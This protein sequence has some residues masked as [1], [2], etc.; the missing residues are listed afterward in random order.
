M[1]PV[2]GE[3]LERRV[4]VRFDLTD[5]VHVVL[6][7]GTRRIP[8]R[9]ID[10]ALAGCAV[11]CDVDTLVEGTKV[12]VILRGASEADIARRDAL[13]VSCF[14]L[15]DEEESERC[16]L[17]FDR[18]ISLESHAW[19]S[20]AVGSPLRDFRSQH[21]LFE[22]QREI[23]LRDLDA[24]EARA[25]D[26]G[27]CQFQ[28]FLTGIPV[29]LGLLGTAFAFILRTPLTG[30]PAIH[31]WVIVLPAASAMTAISML[32]VLLRKSASIAR[33]R[34][35]SLLLQRYLAAGRLPGRY[36]GREDA[37]ANLEHITRFG[38]LE[39]SLLTVEPMGK[40][41][42]VLRSIFSANSFAGLSILILLLVQALSLVGV[43]IL[44][45]LGGSDT[46]VHLVIAAVATSLVAAAGVNSYGLIRRV[47]HGDL[48][49]EYMVIQLSRI[50]EH[51]A[52]FDPW[53]S[54]GY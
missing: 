17:Y 6:L 23:A 5:A 29:F 19:L 22:A 37:L 15:A 35:L 26:S 21:S 52:M 54:K 36:R 16:G 4:G 27:S 8:V 20:M 47:Y 40:G 38:L 53:R 2:T 49:T 14:P 3:Q 33:C 30:A 43:W 46:G 1:M 42:P 10:F 41:A 50:L 48:S 28:L 45:L 18:P 31:S 11:A 32:V 13:V 39:G 24:L 34:A 12:T 9:L 51:A 25:R 7:A 44:A